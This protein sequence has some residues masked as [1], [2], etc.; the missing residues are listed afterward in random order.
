MLSVKEIE[1]HTDYERMIV[2]IQLV[3]APCLCLLQLLLPDCVCFSCCSLICACS[4]C[5]TSI[6]SALVAAP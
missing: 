6:V 1:E 5:C 3:A 4:S 2:T